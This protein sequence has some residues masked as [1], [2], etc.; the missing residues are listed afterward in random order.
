MFVM[1]GGHAAVHE[2]ATRYH[3]SLDFASSLS[4]AA[5]ALA[6]LARSQFITSMRS[7]NGVIETGR[8]KIKPGKWS[9]DMRS[10]GSNKLFLKFNLSFPTLIQKI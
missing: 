1:E 7:E 6:T 4:F 10:N 5:L 3:G 2:I 9:S 8:I